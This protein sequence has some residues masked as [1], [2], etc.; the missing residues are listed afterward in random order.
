MRPHL[1]FAHHNLRSTSNASLKTY[2][3]RRLYEPQR[4]RRRLSD[5]DSSGL[6]SRVSLKPSQALQSAD[7]TTC[8]PAQGEANAVNVFNS[9]QIL[10]KDK[11]RRSG[12]SEVPASERLS[13][14]RQSLSH[15]AEGSK[16]TLEGL[17][18]LCSA[19]TATVSILLH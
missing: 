16:Q 6:N 5:L 1:N 11:R 15:T 4:K 7:R 3:K 12:Q 14:P 19:P 2:S 8:S 13:C 18:Q 17:A 10:H 9:D